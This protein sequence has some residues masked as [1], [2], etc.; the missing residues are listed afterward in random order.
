MFGES[1]RL[2]GCTGNRFNHADCNALV[3]AIEVNKTR[4]T[5]AR[6]AAAST[7]GGDSTGSLACACAARSREFR[8][9]EGPSSERP[10]HGCKLRVSIA[11]LE[12]KPDSLAAE[13]WTSD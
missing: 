2:H 1:V 6:S 11:L 3:A 12:M 5:R 13:D 8:W 4:T 7:H 10:I 9:R